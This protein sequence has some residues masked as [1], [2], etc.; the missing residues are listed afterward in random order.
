MK[1]QPSPRETGVENVLFLHSIH[2]ND[3]SFLFTVSL[4]II[5]VDLKSIKPDISHNFTIIM[6]N[7]G[8]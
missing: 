3:Q 1:T 7:G 8:R 5:Y 6:N 2:Q 4:I